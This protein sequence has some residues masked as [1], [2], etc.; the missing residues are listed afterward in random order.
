MNKKRI[1]IFLIP[2][3]IFL[4]V[5]IIYRIIA[6]TK[7][8]N[9]QNISNIV[10]NDP[11]PIATQKDTIVLF[12]DYRDPFK[13]GSYR[14]IKK[15][16]TSDITPI[17][18]PKIIK[19]TWPQIEFGGIVKKSGSETEYA[20]VKVNDKTELMAYKDEI[21]GLKIRNLTSDSI[22]IELQNETKTF[23][24]AVK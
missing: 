7:P 6:Y 1:N 16:S 19:P 11:N 15:T 4:W 5:L 9:P 3:V 18:K 24:K 13:P 8:S 2:A 14:I 20:V 21:A 17:I 10:Y 22:Q 23:K 12:A